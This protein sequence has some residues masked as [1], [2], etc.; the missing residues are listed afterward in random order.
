MRSPVVVRRPTTEAQDELQTQHVQTSGAPSEAGAQ[1]N[2]GLTG[3]SRPAWQ[4]N[5]GLETRV[6]VN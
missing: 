1:F 2:T 4:D 5:F 3:C 6:A